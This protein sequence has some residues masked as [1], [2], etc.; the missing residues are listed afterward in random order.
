MNKH[1]E[2]LSVFLLTALCDVTEGYSKRVEDP[3]VHPCCKQRAKR[4]ARMHKAPPF[5]QKH[6][7]TFDLV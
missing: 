3:A 2:S 7:L 1:Q 5:S 6:H 4:T